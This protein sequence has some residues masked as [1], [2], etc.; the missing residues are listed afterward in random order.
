M[1]VACAYSR[2]KIITTLSTQLFPATHPTLVAHCNLHEM[3]QLHDVTGMTDASCL[4]QPARPMPI[5]D[6][7]R[8]ERCRNRQM[9]L[10][11]SCNRGASAPTRRKSAGVD[12]EKK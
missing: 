5:N 4:M 3:C 11:I 8:H 7:N 10:I 12:L 9:Q 2:P 6:V 1:Q